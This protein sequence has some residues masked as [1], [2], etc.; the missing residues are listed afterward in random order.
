MVPPLVSL[1]I[2]HWLHALWFSRLS[3]EVPARHGSPPSLPPPPPPPPPLPVPRPVPAPVPA[4]VPLA[5]PL[6]ALADDPPIPP[7]PVVT[8]VPAPPV[9]LSPLFE[10]SASCMQPA[11]NHETKIIDEQILKTFCLTGPD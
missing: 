3:I 10:S 6:P 8:V 1:L 11:P 4:P 5:V 7:A 2:F 9:V